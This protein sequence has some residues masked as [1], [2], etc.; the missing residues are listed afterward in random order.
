[1]VSE[2]DRV[3]EEV[4]RD[5]GLDKQILI[6]AIEEAVLKAAKNEFG[7]QA[8]MEV[9]FNTEIGEVELFEFKSVVEHV[10]N[11]QKEI[12]LAEAKG[13]DPET[14]IGDSLGIKIPTS[15]FGR[16]AAQAA[17]QV[18]IQNIREAERDNVYTEYKDKKGALVTGYIQRFDRGN[19]IVNLG[20]GEAVIPSQ[21]QIPGEKYQQ[22]DRIKAYVLDVKKTPKGPQI[23]LS[24]THPNILMKLFEL[25]VPEI[26]EGVV[27][28]RGVAREPGSRTKI[29]VESR[30]S[31]VDPVG[32]FVGM[33]GSRVQSVVQELRGEKIDI[34]RYDENPAKFACNALSPAQISEVI[35]DEDAHAMEVIV[36]D[37]Q[38]SLAIGKKGQNVRLAVKLVGWKIDI[39]SKAKSTGLTKRAIDQLMEIEGVGESTAELLFKEGFFSPEEIALAKIDDLTKI[40]GIGDKKAEKIKLAAQDVILKRR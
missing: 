34:V 9:H 18:I 23:L 11:S 2:L 19:V 22:R 37:D 14:E 4:R 8:E 30:D 6:S 31:K 17:K 36:E 39:K 29:A 10:R 40:S 32:S 38:L 12:S 13:L 33:K 25:E 24:R 16:I 7:P 28:I 27:K 20:K 3:L 35:V 15:T 26:A 1:M 21:E 5:K